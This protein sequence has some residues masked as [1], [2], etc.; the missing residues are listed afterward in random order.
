MGNSFDDDLRA[1]LLAALD[2]DDVTPVE[3][4]VPLPP[5]GSIRRGS[6]VVLL[7][8]VS[9]AYVGS[10]IATPDPPDFVMKR[11][12]TKWAGMFQIVREKK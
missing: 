8:N 11:V 4:V 7:D 6:V 12:P 3:G 1:I 9:G 2:D 10:D 5:R